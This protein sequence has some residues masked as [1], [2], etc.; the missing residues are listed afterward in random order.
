MSKNTIYKIHCKIGLMYCKI[1]FRECLLILLK[2][3][4][5][6]NHETGSFICIF[7]RC[8]ECKKAMLRVLI[9]QCLCQSYPDAYA[10]Q[11]EQRLCFERYCFMHKNYYFVLYQ[12]FTQS[13]FNQ[14][15]TQSIIFVLNCKCYNHIHTVVS[16]TYIMYTD[17]Y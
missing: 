17:F 15:I 9:R 7:V 10:S 3:K 12:N 2:R 4:H 13:L 14:S 11:F 5:F 1:F 8:F 6:E 16:N